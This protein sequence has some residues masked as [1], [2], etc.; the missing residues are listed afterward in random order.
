MS[1]G[2]ISRWLVVGGWWL[3]VGPTFS[4]LLV[5][6]VEVAAWT[7]TA[8]G[9]VVVLELVRQLQIG[10]RLLGRLPCLERGAGVFEK[11]PI[12]LAVVDEILPLHHGAVA[13]DDAV[14]ILDA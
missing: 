6:H 14:D 11:Q 3:V 5:D 9:N 13:G 12:E 1:M 8:A 10:H 2:P 7:A 4:E